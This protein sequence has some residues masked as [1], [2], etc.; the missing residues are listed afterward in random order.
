MSKPIENMNQ[1]T[2][3]VAT[4]ILTKNLE[5]QFAMELLKSE[6][7]SLEIGK[8][9][10]KL[11]INQAQLLEAA[12]RVWEAAGIKGSWAN[13][14]ILLPAGE[15]R[16]KLAVATVTMGATMEEA[17]A[18]LTW[19]EFEAFCARVLEENG[20]S[21]ILEFRFKSI[22]RKRY[23]CDILASK[24]PLILMADCKHYAGRVKGLRA[25]V[26][27]Q[28]ERVSNLCRSVPTMVRSIPE[29][30]DWSEA[31]VIPVI[32]TLFP[33]N[34]S[35]MD[36]VPVV[37]GFKLNQF[38]QELPSNTDGIIHLTIYPSRQE[39]LPTDKPK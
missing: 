17:A 10:K 16:L 32:I 35:I 24:K 27:K 36:D 3:F 6:E 31:F 13:T 38:I 37:P 20:Y 15:D 19:K 33:E 9:S 22:Q 14:R 1:M 8:L 26:E 11:N 28:I 18:I 4:G 30:V 29:V 7:E 2:R 25:V 21:C 5:L 12:D 39:K 34:P 23:E